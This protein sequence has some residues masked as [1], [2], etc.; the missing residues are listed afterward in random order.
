MIR[1]ARTAAQLLLAMA[2]TAVLTYK[3]AAA[4]VACTVPSSRYAR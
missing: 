4:L 3:V 1:H 2:V